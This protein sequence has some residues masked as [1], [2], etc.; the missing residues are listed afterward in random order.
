[1]WQKDEPA[2]QA[3]SQKQAVT[4]YGSECVP[5]IVLERP[6]KEAT[7][8]LPMLGQVIVRMHKQEE[9]CIAQNILNQEQPGHSIATVLLLIVAR[10]TV[11]HR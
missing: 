11:R 10:L 5:C 4:G 2:S 8:E 3:M 7:D 6:R 9:I 1:M